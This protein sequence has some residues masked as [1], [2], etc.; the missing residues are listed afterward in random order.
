MAISPFISKPNFLGVSNS[1]MNLEENG[2]LKN[3]SLPSVNTTK[4]TSGGIISQA[5]TTADAI[6]QAEAIAN[7]LYGDKTGSEP[8]WGVASLLYFSKM[9]EE[10]SKPGATFAGSVGSAFTTPAAYLMEKEKQA[11]AK[12]TKRASLVAGLVPSLMKD[13]SKKA[14]FYTLSEDVAGV[15]KKGQTLNYTVKEFNALQPNVR[16]ALIP[17]KPAKEGTSKVIDM[18]PVMENGKPKVNESGQVIHKFNVEDATGN[19]TQTYESTRKSGDTI[20][21]GGDKK[22]KEEF[23]KGTAKMSVEEFKKF[24]EASINAYEK[25][26]NVEDLLTM[27]ADPNLETGWDQET[28]K[29]PLRRIGAALGFNVDLSKIASQEAFRA[30]TFEIVLDNVSKMKGALSDK[31][32]GFLQ[33]MNANLGMQKNANKL[34]LLS[35]HLALKKAERFNQFA[36]DWQKENTKDED[37]VVQGLKTSL[38]YQ[39]MIADFRADKFNQLNPRDYITDLVDKEESRLVVAMGGQVYKEGDNI[40]QGKKI[41]DYIPDTLTIAQENEIGQQL[42]NKFALSLMNSVFGNVFRPGESVYGTKKDK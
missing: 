2:A 19:V 17:F 30:K 9:A 18:G 41:G 25:R 22:A 23:A 33:N 36:L 38:Q 34:L 3:I 21:I 27:L 15:G 24:R 31:E 35:T 13:T 5:G 4:D 40:P 32:L 12:D 39:Q 1:D 14:D 37:G 10:A 26:K 11:Q 8:D 29:L 7:T 28:F 42:E 6:K 20:N 16:S